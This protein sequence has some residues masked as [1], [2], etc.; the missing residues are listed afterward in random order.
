MLTS[1]LI[2]MKQVKLQFQKEIRSSF[3]KNLM[4][5]FFLG[6]SFVTFAQSTITGKVTDQKGEPIIG[7][8]IKAKGTG[9]GTITDINGAFKISSNG[10][11]LISYIG[12]QPQEVQVKG[13]SSVE[14]KLQEDEKTLD[15]LVV[16]GYGT[17]KKATLTGAVDVVSNKALQDRA[18]TNVGLALQ[19]QTPGL[20]VTRTSPRPG[21]EGLNFVIRGVSSVNGSKPLVIIDGVPALNDQSFLNMNADDIENISVLKDGAAAIYGSRASNGVILVTTKRGKGKVKVDYNGSLRF[22]TNG[23]VG[24]SPNMQQYATSWIEANKEESVPNWWVFQNK[25]NMLKMQQGVEGAYPLFGIDYF[26]FNSNRLDEMFS[27]QLSQQHNLSISNGTDKSSYRISL[28]FADNRG[29]L[30]TAYD[31][32]KQYNARFNYDY[33]L[34]EKLKVETSISLVDTKTSSPSVGLDNT[35]YGYDMPFFP[36][37]NPY[38]QWFACFNGVDS[39]ANRNAAAMT[40]DG[41]RDNKNSLTGRIDL[42]ATYQIYKD[43]AF[44]ALGSLQNERFN[45]EKYVLQVPVY[46]WYG[47]QT[48]IGN[49]TGGTNNRYYTKAYTSDYQYYLTSLRYTKK[50]NDVHNFGAMAGVEAEKS[51]YQW[52]DATRIGFDNLG[53]QDI[54]LAS[55]ATQTNGGFKSLNGRYSYLAKVNYNYADKYLIEL[56]GRRDGNSRFATGYKFKNFGSALLGWV[57]TNE[58]FLK[59]ITSVM[60]F[61]KIR[62][63]FSS[64]GNEASGLG[65]FDY[66]STVNVGTT[67]LGQ[68]P[69][70][71]Q[72]TSLN[73][74]GLISY[75][76]TW[77]R[78]EQKNIAVDLGFFN[79]RLS[80]S[81]DYYI[82]DNIGMLIGVNY[83]SVLGGSAPKTNNGHFNTKG[84]EAVIGWKDSKKD[85]SYNVSFNIGDANTL[86]TNVIGAD[87]YGAGRNDIVN[88]Y[89]Y[90]S[91]FVYKTDGYFKDQAEVDA[92]YTKYGSS[93]D[94]A[95]LQANNP[96]GTLRPGDTKKVDVAG[97]GNITANG[98]AKSS[99]VYAG[100][101]TS[102]FVFGFNMGGSWKG[103]DLSAFFQGQFK[104]QIMR[105]GW[106]AY[107]FQ[108]IWTNQN[109]AFLGKTWTVDN[110]NAAFPRLTVN[111]DRA[112]WNYANN[113][114]Q[115]QNNK[116]IRLKSLV[117]GYTLPKKVTNNL[118]LDKLRVYF[119]GNDLWE[120]ANIKDG[121]DPEMGEASVDNNGYPYAR[122]WSFGLNIGF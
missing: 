107:P 61:G 16:V 26:I 110:P 82:K 50:I 1:K 18:I 23:I 51:S 93:A 39:G 79:S 108:A 24:Y 77:E 29:N 98:N 74:G 66:L 53:V 88:G 45:N 60:N 92:Y 49:G 105:S 43:L 6:M 89:A 118:K 52:V 56:M 44:E 28:G 17:Q 106:M 119:S 48:G 100:D 80:G 70:Q 102:H 67:V 32:Q 114:F 64:T 31:G 62:A 36:A 2:I 35:L 73:N 71:Q 90:K 57:F 21:N 20:V 4:L 25:D 87:N 11:L 8:S 13:K 10:T 22:T 86:V 59:G 76:R 46:N 84:W 117:V 33:K 103:F 54:S 9:V 42:K 7:A 15:E 41:G 65:E 94:L 72:S 78:V 3:K 81:F 111:P 112:A 40:T 55:T 91:W 101:G 121:F 34:T 47:V 96:K 27:T 30:A 38:G 122:T 120:W 99:L 75:T 14:V 69:A 12:Y 104:Q 116:Y 19:G 115:L 95:K 68:T 58:S 97:T 109:P 85:F 37:K 63:T 5:L 113:D 83:P